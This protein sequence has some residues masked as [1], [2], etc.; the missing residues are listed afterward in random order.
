METTQPT[1][2]TAPAHGKKILI[3]SAHPDPRSLTASLASF[4][5]AELRRSGHEVRTSDLYAM[6]WRAEVTAD[7]FPDFERLSPDGRL[8]VMEVSGRA[9][10]EGRLSPDIAAEQEKL[11]WADA[12]I[13]QFPLWWF[14]APAIVKGWFDRVLT[15]NF[16]YFSSGNPGY[17]GGTLAGRRALVAVTL[18]AGEPSFSPRGIHG[19]LAD[20][21]FPIQHG[22]L[23]FTG[24]DVLEPFAVFGAAELDDARYA[25]VTAGYGE[26][27]RALFTDEPIPFRSLR[28][29]DYTRSLELRPEV[30]APGVTGFDLHLRTRG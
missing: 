14:S 9:T 26:R 27:L 22:V 4:A 24:M 13:L 20:V 7:D 18:G 17:G 2:R 8:D 21:L 23:F 1:D 5:E 10:A 12:V 6:K 30:E 28:D 29:G 3:V 15:N 16:G 11:L 19:P 25:E